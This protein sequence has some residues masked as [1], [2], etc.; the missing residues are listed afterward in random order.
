[1]RIMAVAILLGGV[2]QDFF[3][4]GKILQVEFTVTIDEN[5]GC[6]KIF[7]IFHIFNPPPGVWIFV[8]NCFK[9]ATGRKWRSW[10]KWFKLDFCQMSRHHTPPE[11][12]QSHTDNPQAPP[13]HLPDTPIFWII[14]G[15]WEKRKK[16]MYMSQIWCL[17]I[18]CTSYPPRQ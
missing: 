9:V 4:V 2:V 3:R 7:W 18:A 15:N 11:S 5:H 17:S 13:R 14:W 1:M 16:L 10:L 8:K 6:K 12:I